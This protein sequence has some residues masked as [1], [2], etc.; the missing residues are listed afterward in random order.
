MYLLKN[1]LRIQMKN[2]KFIFQKI[3]DQKSVRGSP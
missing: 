3:V 1:G 2:N